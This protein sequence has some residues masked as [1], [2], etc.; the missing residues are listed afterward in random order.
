MREYL[1]FGS[2]ILSESNSVEVAEFSA[3]HGCSI[4]QAGIDPMP[5]GGNCIFFDKN[6]EVVNQMKR[7][8]KLAYTIGEGLD[9]YTITRAFQ[10][11]SSKKN[12]GK[13]RNGFL[14][15]RSNQKEETQPLLEKKPD[16]CCRIL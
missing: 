4:I 8:L 14:N 9:E 13:S 5:I 1:V 2:G 12:V 16:G 6:P 7:E 11:I 3:K 15:G 10:D